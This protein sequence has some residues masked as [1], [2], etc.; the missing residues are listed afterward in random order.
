MGT[1][2][3]RII[4]DVT[5]IE[6]VWRAVSQLRAAGRRKDRATSVPGRGPTRRAAVSQ[7]TCTSPATRIRDRCHY[8]LNQSDQEEIIERVSNQLSNDRS[9]HRDTSVDVGGQHPQAA[10]S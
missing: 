4:C 3:I 10:E 2:D 1:D 8:R 7:G 5:S 9:A 6:D